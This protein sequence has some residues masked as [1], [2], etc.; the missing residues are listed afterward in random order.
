MSSI[1]FMDFCAGIGGGRL[2]LTKNGFECIGFSEIDKIA[3]KTYRTF[4]GDEEK[5]WGDLTQIDTTELPNFDIM[6]GGFPCQTFSVVGKRAGFEDER[7][8]IIYHLIKILKEKQVPFFILENV[9]GLV[10]H[11]KGNTLK[12][13]VLKLDD[14]GYDV[15]YKVLNSINYGVPQMRERIYFVGI[16]KGKTKRKFK[17]P[18]NIEHYDIENFIRDD[19]C[20]ELDINDITFNKYLNNK[21]NKGKF[22][23]EE[24]LDKDYLVLDTRQSD[25]RLYEN[26]IPTLRTGRHGILYVKNKKLY[27]LSGLDGLLFQGFPEK[28]VDKAKKSNINNNKLLSQVGNAMTVT[29][30]QA[31]CEELLNCVGGKND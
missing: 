21:Y 6:I 22:K 27:K 8:Q 25:L 3:E 12:E 1:K 10:N 30:I 26:K 5:N 24:I 17:W 31:I 23:I 14:A 16:K 28:L 9:K 11:D 7:G 15:H 13:I 19:N 4:F 2:G 29:V 18:E 20:I